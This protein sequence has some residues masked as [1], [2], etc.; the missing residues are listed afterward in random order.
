M[1]TMQTRDDA[2]RAL[3]LGGVWTLLAGFLGLFAVAIGLDVLPDDREY[4]VLRF[5]GLVVALVGSGLVVAGL[6]L[7]ALKR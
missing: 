5:L 3:L 6:A 1:T 4:D 2:G 7:R